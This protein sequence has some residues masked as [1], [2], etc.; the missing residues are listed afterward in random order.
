[1][2]YTQKKRCQTSSVGPSA[3]MDSNI[4]KNPTVLMKTEET[5]PDQFLRFTKNWSD[6][7]Q[8]FQIKKNK[9]QKK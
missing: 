1:M 7:I 3:A 6:T 5:S 9:N 4:N 8:N 2:K